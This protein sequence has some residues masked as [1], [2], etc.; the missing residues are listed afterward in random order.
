MKLLFIGLFLL[1]SVT[2]YA[3]EVKVINYQIVNEEYISAINEDGSVSTIP[4]NV[5]NSDYLAY[6]SWVN[7]G[8]KANAADDPIKV[9]RVKLQ[10][11]WVVAHPV[12]ENVLPDTLRVVPS[13]T[14]PAT[15]AVK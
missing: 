2:I 1:V 14:I 8:N 15:S 3:A 5:K 4:Q 7:A 12:S 9:D 11:D 13:D 6:L 10:A